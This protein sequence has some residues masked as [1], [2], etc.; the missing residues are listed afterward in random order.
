M[1]GNEKAAICLNHKLSVK[2]T[3]FKKIT[4]FRLNYFVTRSNANIRLKK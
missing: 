3:Q 1:K 4:L 2:M